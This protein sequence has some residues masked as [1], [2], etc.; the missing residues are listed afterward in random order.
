MTPDT[1]QH[2]YDYHFAA[3]R[4]VWNEGELQLTKQQFIAKVDY[5]VGSIR[6]HVIHLINVD[7]AWFADLRGLTSFK[8]LNPVHYT[9]FDKIRAIWD[10]V[11]ATM[12]T[13]LA[14]LDADMLNSK[15]IK[16]PDTAHLTV[17][18]SLLHIANHG[19]DHRAQMLMLLNQAGVETFPQDYA[20]YLMEPEWFGA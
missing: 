17:A 8:R 2:L 20:F 1:F 6:N 7:N 16:E 12:K 11:E 9:D 10:E 18:Q 15:P 3:N 4:K 19:T 14:T 13:Y 5:S